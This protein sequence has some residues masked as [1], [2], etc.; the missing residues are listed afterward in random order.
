MNCISDN[1]SFPLPVH[2]KTGWPWTGEYPSI[3]ETMTDG[4][5]WPKISVV[6]PSFN[7]GKYIEETIRSVL[8]QGY[9]NLEY[10][11]IDGDS[12]DNSVEIIKK[13]EPWLN[14]WI[15]E[16]DTG[17][18]NAINKGMSRAS[19]KILAYLNSDDI[20]MPYTFRLV[21]D[22]FQTWSSI[23][24]ITGHRS[25]LVED[26]VISPMPNACWIFNQKMFQKG[27]HTA[28][29]FGVN[30]QPSTFWKRDLFN[31]AGGQF[32][33]NF[34]CSMDIDLWIKMSKITDLVYLRAV[35][36]AMRQ[37]ADQKSGRLG[38]DYKEIEGHSDRYG[39]YPLW[40]RKILFAGIQVP[41]VR[42]LL[43]RSWCDGKGRAVQWDKKK[44]QWILT[45][46]YLF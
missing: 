32:D 28:W 2:D 9:P 29:F 34:E 17:Q 26:R 18:T 11:I 43:R 35:L 22:I 36:T 19:G 16:P 15:T 39:F 25:H 30:Q 12:R 7:Q 42:G 45:E 38:L 24:W 46:H 3:P 40:L 14:Y 10:F 21:A 44:H 37:H 5:P 27:F 13:Y 33:E 41:V 4:S 31:K 20:Y 6:T 8:L 23:Q 1:S